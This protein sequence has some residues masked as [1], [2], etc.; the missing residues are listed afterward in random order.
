MFG[1]VVMEGMTPSGHLSNINE[2]DSPRWCEIETELETSFQNRTTR[3]ND[4]SA[5]GDEKAPSQYISRVVKYNKA[6][7]QYL[8]AFCMPMY[9]TRG[10]QKYER[11]IIPTLAF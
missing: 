6:S 5:G 8:T 11:N 3:C 9:L 10:L 2:I 7:F 1:L 4:K